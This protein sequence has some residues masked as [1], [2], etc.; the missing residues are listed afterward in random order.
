MFCGHSQSGIYSDPVEAPSS[1]PKGTDHS[2]HPLTGPAISTHTPTGH[3]SAL[4]LFISRVY[5]PAFSFA[6]TQQRQST[7]ETQCVHSTSMCHVHFKRMCIFN[8]SSSSSLVPPQNP[9]QKWECDRPAH[10]NV[11]SP[12]KPHLNR[13]LSLCREI[14]TISNDGLWPLCVAS[15]FVS[16][17][18][19][20]V[21]FLFSQLR[22]ADTEGITIVPILLTRHWTREDK[23]LPQGPW[24]KNAHPVVLSTCVTESGNSV[25]PMSL[26]KMISLSEPVSLPMKW[27]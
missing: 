16:A 14:A 20:R 25:F 21:S 3:R 11:L 9:L 10:T 6:G 18:R 8:F 24:A 5:P 19:S 7:D 17:R 27:S 12:L 2:K 23:R 15:Q 26:G 4:G 22:E 1:P 13:Y